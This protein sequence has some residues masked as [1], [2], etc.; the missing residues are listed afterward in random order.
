MKRNKSFTYEIIAQAFI[1][2]KN[3]AVLKQLLLFNFCSFM[4]Y[5]SLFS[6]IKVVDVT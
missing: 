1:Y 6:S 3:V 4:Y 2:D 5:R